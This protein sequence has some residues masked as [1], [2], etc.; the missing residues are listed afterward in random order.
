[1]KEKW[2]EINGYDG[3]SVSN[4]GKIKSFRRKSYKENG[5]TLTPET[6]YKGCEQVSYGKKTSKISS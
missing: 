4:T 5:L 3:Y 2:K 1:M 6:S